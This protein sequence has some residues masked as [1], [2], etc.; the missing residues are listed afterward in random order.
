[1]VDSMAQEVALIGAADVVV[2]CACGQSSG[3]K[4]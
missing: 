2:A 3:F 4:S 1:V